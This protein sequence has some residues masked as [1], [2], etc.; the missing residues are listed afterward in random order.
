M[1]SGKENLMKKYYKGYDVFYSFDDEELKELEFYDDNDSSFR[2]C[3]FRKGSFSAY[4]CEVYQTIID[5]TNNEDEDEE[6]E[7]FSNY[8]TFTCNQFNELCRAN[9]DYLTNKIF[10]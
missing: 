3:N 10:N 8:K 5:W 1:R 4:E 2:Y 6:K 9:D 7:V